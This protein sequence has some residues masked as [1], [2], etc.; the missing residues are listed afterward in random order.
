MWELLSGKYPIF[1]FLG[2]SINLQKKSYNK[3][4]YSFFFNKASQ[5]LMDR[6]ISNI[7][8]W[9]IFV[10]NNITSYCFYL[11]VPANA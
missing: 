11:Q 9:K 4:K 2:T 5:Q 3:N 1:Q 6:F 7:K 10:S 8:F